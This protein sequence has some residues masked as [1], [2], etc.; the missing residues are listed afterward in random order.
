MFTGSECLSTGFEYV[1][2][3]LNQFIVYL[4]P[5]IIVQGQYSFA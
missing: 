2:C 4:I 3:V 5:F 1:I